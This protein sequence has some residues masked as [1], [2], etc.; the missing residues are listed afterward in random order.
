MC[1]CMQLRIPV[2]S[3]DFNLHDD[4]LCLTSFC[5]L[6]GNLSFSEMSVPVSGHFLIRLLVSL[7]NG[8][9]PLP[10]DLSLLSVLCMYC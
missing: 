6:I 9:N 4:K 3:H 2:L 7:Q 1:I 8:W 10:K 5:M